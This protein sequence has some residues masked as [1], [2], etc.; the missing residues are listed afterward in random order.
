[1][2][3]R[4]TQSTKVYVDRERET[5]VLKRWNVGGVVI[6]GSCCFHQGAVVR[7]FGR[8]CVMLNAADVAVDVF[9]RSR[10]R[11]FWTFVDHFIAT[12]GSNRL[13]KLWRRN[14]P[15][16]WKIKDLL[17]CK[18]KIIFQPDGYAERTC[19]ATC[20]INFGFGHR[21]DNI[22]ILKC[23]FVVFYLFVNYCFCLWVSWKCIIESEEIS[24]YNMQKDP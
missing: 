13:Q 10:I 7:N 21:L 17:N 14:L 12:F 5:S 23:T 11:L 15:I 2:S 3:H 24:I 8:V 4:L 18:Y 19:A 6:P 22:R 9:S 1:M 20:F 16:G